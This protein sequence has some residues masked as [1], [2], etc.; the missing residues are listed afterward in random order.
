MRLLL[1]L[2]V[3]LCLLAQPMGALAATGSAMTGTGATA[4]GASAE[5]TRNEA[6]TYLTLP[7]WSIVY[8]ADEYAAFLKDHR[9]S[10]FPYHAAKQEYLRT[11]AAVLDAIEGR[12]EYD[13]GAKLMLLVIGVSFT[14]ENA[15]KGLYEN[16]IGRLSEW[17]AGNAVTDEDRFMQATAE[18]YGRFVHD[19]PWYEFPFLEKL[20]ELWTET[21]WWDE[22]PVRKWERKLALSLEYGVKAAYGWLIGL[23]TATVYDP[24]ELTIDYVVAGLSPEEAAAV[25]GL[26]AIRPTG[27][28][29]LAVTG[30]RYEAFTRTTLAFARRG[31]EFVEIAGNDEILVTALAPSGWTEVPP[32]A[33]ELF[34]FERVTDP[35]SVRVAL[36]TEVPRLGSVIRA[37]EARNVTV[38]H[39]YDY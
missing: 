33:T 25:P 20:R 28:G 2:T 32:G 38:E 6:W 35:N 10:A 19:T 16:S 14:V 21:S 1:P 36:R 22:A 8:S 12:Y 13:A 24:A 23:G 18:E 15:L 27:S 26:Q 5:R 9:P 31:A 3:A 11:Y 7:E 34:R 17:H 37:L 29:T 4:S 30:P 39:V